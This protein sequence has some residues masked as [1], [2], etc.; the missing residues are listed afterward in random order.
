MP[1]V[2]VS[3]PLGHARHQRQHRLGA[4]QRLHPGLLI[5]AQHHRPL[6]RV[7]VEPDRVDDLST[8]CGSVESLKK[9]CT[10]GMSSN[11]RQ[12]RPIVVGDS[13]DPESVA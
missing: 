12:I 1:H 7:V 2:V 3:A 8:N 10:C 4:V 6:G 5:H 13:Q 9:S 11:W